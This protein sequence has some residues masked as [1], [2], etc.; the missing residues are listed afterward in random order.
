MGE[1]AAADLGVR[2]G[3]EVILRLLLAREIARF[4]EGF[5]QPDGGFARVRVVGIARAPTW[6]EPVHR[7][8]RDAGLRPC[9]RGGRLGPRCVRPAAVHRPGVPRRLHRGADRG[10]RRRPV[11]LSAGR[12]AAVPSPRSR[13]PARPDGA[14][15]AGRPPRGAGRV[16]RGRGPERAPGGRAGAAAAPRQPPARPAHR[17]RTGDDPRRARGGAGAGRCGRSRRPRGWRAP[18]SRSPPGWSGR[19]AARP[20]SSRRRGSGRRGP[21]PWGAERSSRCCSWR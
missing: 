8:R 19:W 17:A 12:A 4:A 15:R 9:A 1:P 5:G 18:W 21:S 3:D 20:A 7:P 11:H 14:R 16:R 6:A 13:P 10:I 2:V